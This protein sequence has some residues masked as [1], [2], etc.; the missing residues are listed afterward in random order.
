ME[1]LIEIALLFLKLGAVGFG[2]PGAH[3]AMMEEEFVRKRGW[4]SRGHFLDIVGA[5]NLIP[6]PNSTEIALHLGYVRAGLP[7]LLVAG[8][9]FIFPAVLMTLG[10]AWA[11][12]RW[13]SLPEAS[14]FSVGVKGALFAVMLG[15]CIHLGRAAL[16][17]AWHAALGAFVFALAASQVGEVTSFFV[18]TACGFVLLLLAARRE[19][20]GGGGAVVLFFGF[21]SWAVPQA[22]VAA[23]LTGEGASFWKL[24]LFFLKVGSILY[25]SGLVLVAYLD[26][27][28]VEH[29]GWITRRE[30]LDA[31][32]VGQMTPGPV[33]TAS[34]FIGYTILGWEGALAAT[35]GVFLPSFVLVLALAPFLGRVRMHRAARCFL[36][37]AN[38]SS[39]ALIAAV[40]ASVAGD[41][42][43]SWKPALIATLA[44]F[45]HILFRV[46][47]GLVILGGGILG[48]VLA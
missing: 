37:A 48:L 2:G 25:G 33:V 45:A 38:V 41:A 42:F 7:G 18:G 40:T 29:L 10:I 17:T 16:K 26:G 3:I 30:L 9:G 13:G 19:K 46:P 36:D 22:V 12:V 34:T 20:R 14:S 1:K 31:I 23:G 6:G 15:A 43:A 4:L 27:G 35:G 5:T 24:G 44:V 28:L 32:A 8:V 11:Y 39:I 47:T 21:V